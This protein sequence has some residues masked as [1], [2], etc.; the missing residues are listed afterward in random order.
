MSNTGIDRAKA[1]AAKG[2]RYGSGHAFA[3]GSG[4]DLFAVD[5]ELLRDAVAN[6]CL[7]GDCVMFSLTSD[8][9]AACVRVLSNDSTDKWYPADNTQFEGLLR[10]IRDI[11]K[12]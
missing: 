7:A 12:G 4:L 8:Q 2:G 5:G 1:K 6:A 11:A 10:A 9:G 3:S